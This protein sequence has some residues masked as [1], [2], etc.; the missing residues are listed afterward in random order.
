MI[1]WCEIP[2]LQSDRLVLRKLVRE[3]AQSYY[4]NLG[5]REAVTRYMLFDPHT[6]ISQSVD[7]V[8]KALRRYDEGKCYRWAVTEKGNEELIGIVEL[9][10]F[11]ETDNSC[12]FAYMLG[13]S[14]WGKGYGTEVLRTVFDFAFHAMDMEVIRADHMADNPASGRCMEKAGMHRTGVE[15]G[16]YVKHGISHDAVCYEIRR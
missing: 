10:R 5:S 13:D 12:S 11:D 2:V 14:H 16:K 6:D 4:R 3:D 1:R 8:E 9:L 7:S 15:P